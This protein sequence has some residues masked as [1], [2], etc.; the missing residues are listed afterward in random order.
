M[1]MNRRLECTD[2]HALLS[3]FIDD[4]LPRNE[5]HDMECHLT[6]CTSC[7]DAIDRAERIE[8]LIRG[9]ARLV[10]GDGGLSTHAM[11]LVIGRTVGAGPSGAPRNRALAWSGWL[12]AAA[13]VA[14]AALLHNP[15]G[16]MT[17]PE[18]G[19]SANPQ[20]TTALASASS[21][22]SWHRSWTLEGDFPGA[23]P[24]SFASA[25][26]SP[27]PTAALNEAWNRSSLRSD[28]EAV[29]TA[30]VVLETFID[31]DEEGF[32]AVE[33]VRDVVVFDEL[34]ARLARVRT[35]LDVDDRRLITAAETLL[36]RI[37]HDPLDEAD[38]ADM[39]DLVRRVDLTEALRRIGDRGLARRS[40]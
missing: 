4:E 29:H 16:P 38:L 35:T 40:L 15:G 28:L 10:A 2:I 31:I 36:F 11:D 32:R 12:V 22:S 24:M 5:R 23:A 27:S 30:A 8:D 7:R 34:I 13:T 18:S 25:Q 6:A 20:R 19:D 37:V 14:A 17:Q 21:P 26:E 33:S 39:R 9:D 1:T 3:P